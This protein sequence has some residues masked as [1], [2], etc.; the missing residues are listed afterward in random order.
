MGVLDTVVQMKRQGYPDDEIISQLRQ[1]GLS[2]KEIND[3]LNQSQIKSAV[4]RMDEGAPMPPG[5]Q[6]DVYTPQPQEEAGQE[7]YPA[8]QQAQ[9]GQQE[10][11]PQEDY[12]SQDNQQGVAVNTDTIVEISEQ[13]FAE[14]TKKIQ[15]SM[16]EL[17]EFKTISQSR[18]ENVLD[19]IKKIEAIIDQLQISILEKIGSY[20]S[21]I[22][23]IKKE[24]SM[25]Q[26]S[27][28]KM[29][30]KVAEKTERK[31]EHHEKEH[32]AKSKK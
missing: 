16:D 29:V 6:G 28:G 13:V 24:M 11:Y 12:Y 8:Y 7:M 22:E 2:P 5:Q 17:N 21:N 26:D 19:R 18:I 1:Q 15:K 4:S 27:F 20:G 10:Y 31:E 14:K 32:K 9:G 23:G 3:A 30:G 25:M